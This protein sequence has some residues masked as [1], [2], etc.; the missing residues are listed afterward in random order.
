M[1]IHVVKPGETLYSIA[2]AY[3]V[4]MS[5][6]LNDNQ[7]EDPAHLVVGQTIVVLNPSATYTVRPLDSLQSIARET[8]VSVRQLLRNNP[9]L[10]GED[11]ISTGQELILSYRQEKQ[12]ILAVHAYAYPYIDRALLRST[13]PYL[14]GLLPFTY[15][16]TAEGNLVDLDDAAMIAAAR[17]VGTSPMMHLSTLTE[18]GGFSNNLAHIVLND[19]AVQNALVMN[20]LATIRKKGYRAL[21]IDFEYLF[22]TDAQAYAAFVARM[23][24]LLSPFGIPVI[25]AVA[26]KVFARQPGLLYEGHDYRLL[27][28]AADYVFLMT[29]EWGYTLCRTGSQL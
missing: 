24:Q 7:L 20:L 5:R 13:L 4:P 1:E 19:G 2:L 3:G 11:Q 9:V 29:Y 22:S 15:G 21:D 23:R 27:G 16:I 12:G 28:Q 14:T 6:L 18:E 8:G 17:Q 25:V 26:P 10:Q